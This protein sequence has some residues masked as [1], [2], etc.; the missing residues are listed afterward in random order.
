[1]VT[2]TY[3]ICLLTIALSN[4]GIFT[5]FWPNFPRFFS[6]FSVSLLTVQEANFN[7]IKNLRVGWVFR[8][9]V[10]GHSGLS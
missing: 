5:R 10:T 1:M 2:R 3:A 4:L 6:L 7:E 9:I 8:S